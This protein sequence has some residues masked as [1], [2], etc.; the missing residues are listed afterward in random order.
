MY[1][2]CVCL[3]SALSRRVGALQIIQYY[4]K[5]SMHSL[6]I[7]NRK[8][9]DQRDNDMRSNI[10]IS[11]QGYA[12]LYNKSRKAAYKLHWSQWTPTD[13]CDKNLA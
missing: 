4:Y 13:I 5:E 11:D 9:N 12:I 2:M 8:Q 10:P 1:I 6:C 3:F 7:D